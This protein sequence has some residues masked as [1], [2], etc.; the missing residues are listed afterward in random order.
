MGNATPSSN[1][2]QSVLVVGASSAVGG[3]AIQLLR[4]ALPSA[5]IIATASPA[6]HDHLLSLGASTCISREAQS[7]IAALKANTPGGEGVDAIL[8]TVTAAVSE[9]T[10]FQALKADGSR[11]Y[12]HPVTGQ[13]PSPP[14]GVQATAVF[15][16]QIF[17]TDGGTR[18][19][20]F[21]ASLFE[22]GK[23]KIPTKVE[24][25]G[26]G[27]E[28]IEGALNKLM[29]GVNGKKLVISI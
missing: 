3:H 23:Y 27:L 21:L 10:I 11:L 24:L 12:A 18:A 20:P 25:A 16:R 7:D 19:I 9:P 8:D 17:S 5:T 29:Q 22:Q 15:G 13:N 14:E 4:L 2:P 26:N 6:H 28:S 1:L